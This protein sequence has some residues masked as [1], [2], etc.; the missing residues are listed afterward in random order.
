MKI[1]IKYVDLAINK[2]RISKFEKLS[3]I[4]Y[5]SLASLVGPCLFVVDLQSVIDNGESKSSI[6][7]GGKVNVGLSVEV[8][9]L[10]QQR[11]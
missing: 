2:L 1:S 3:E 8:P 11:D 6:D 4:R 5:D 10:R 9:L 7:V